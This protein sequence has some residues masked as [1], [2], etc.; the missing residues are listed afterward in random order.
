MS[1]FNSSFN[2]CIS[3]LER[4]MDTLE[5]EFQDI[6][7]NLS[8]SDIDK[9]D[10]SSSCH[11]Y[12]KGFNIHGLDNSLRALEKELE[13]L[14]HD[15]IFESEKSASLNFEEY[16]GDY[17]APNLATYS[18]C[19]KFY[20]V[21]KDANK[22]YSDSG[23]CDIEST[24]HSSG[25]LES[26]KSLCS[27]SE[28]ETVFDDQVIVKDVKDNYVY[29]S[30]DEPQS[31]HRHAKLPTSNNFQ[32][33]FNDMDIDMACNFNAMF[34]QRFDNNSDYTVVDFLDDLNNFYEVCQPT[35]KGFMRMAIRQSCGP[36]KNV[37]EALTRAHP[38]IPSFCNAMM[39]MYDTTPS[40]EEANQMLRDLHI[41]KDMPKLKDAILIITQLSLL[42]SETKSF[43]DFTFNFKATGALTAILPGFYWA[44][45]CAKKEKHKLKF[46]KL[47]SFREMC[48]YL[49]IYSNGINAEFAKILSK[50]E[51]ESEQ[52]HA[53]NDNHHNKQ[54]SKVYPCWSGRS[55]NPQY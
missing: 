16:D 34:Y 49:V 24:G 3:A 53:A 23:I 33:N 36:T 27:E 25:S 9:D 15:K 5:K 31:C 47:P 21:P 19:D 42:A 51:E 38:T 45:W 6:N 55:S 1:D 2:E 54:R 46:G 39:E 29:E 37:V 7:F 10:I 40:P 4:C 13:E 14:F 30:D 28:T 11:S 52:T 22:A 48:K 35:T 18:F 17:L 8:D 44:L 50:L 43:D 12:E 41:N 26:L 20:G 32:K